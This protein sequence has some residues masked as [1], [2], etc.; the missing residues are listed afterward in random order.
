MRT[1]SLMVNIGAAG[2]FRWETKKSALSA[3]GLLSVCGHFRFTTSAVIRTH[4]LQRQRRPHRSPRSQPPHAHWME[5]DEPFSDRFPRADSAGRCLRLGSK[6]R[7]GGYTFFPGEQPAKSLTSAVE[8]SGSTRRRYLSK[9]R[10]RQPTAKKLVAFVNN[11][12]S[13]DARS[14]ICGSCCHRDPAQ[15][16]VPSPL[17]MFVSIN[18][19]MLEDERLI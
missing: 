14:T 19:E 3:T 11:N 12:L 17:L 13:D 5:H 7:S 15:K 1:V 2:D 16:N 9:R 4:I 8:Q 10:L 6:T 18:S